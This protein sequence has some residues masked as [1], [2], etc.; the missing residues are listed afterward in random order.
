MASSLEPVTRPVESEIPSDF[1]GMREIRRN[2]ASAQTIPRM[3]A[4]MMIAVAED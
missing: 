1:T 3:A 2:W 4:V